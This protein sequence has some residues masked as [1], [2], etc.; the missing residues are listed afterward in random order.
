[1]GAGQGFKA[2]A[3]LVQDRDA[4][5]YELL[6]S[7]EAGD[8]RGI[9]CR[10]WA[11]GCSR[12]SFGLRS[13][14]FLPSLGR[15]GEGTARGPRGWA[16]DPAGRAA[17]VFDS[18]DDAEISE[19]LRLRL[20]RFR[21]G[22]RA[23]LGDESA[24]LMIGYLISEIF[25]RAGSPAQ[26]TVSITDFRSLLL[27]D[28][29]TLARALGRRDWGSWSGRFPR[30]RT[31][32]ART[33]WTTW[34]PLSRCG[35]GPLERPPRTLTGMS[36]IGKTS[37]A[38]GYLL[39]RADV[40]DTIFWVDAE[41]EQTL[42]SSFSRIF[43]FLRGDD[44]PEPSDPAG[45]RDAVLTD[46]SCVAGPWLLI[47]DNCADERLADGWVPQAEEWSCDSDDYSATPARRRATRG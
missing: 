38:V 30:S 39:D 3:G 27:V 15:P 20:R 18:R 37:L 17:A 36:G 2:L 31:C 16:P 4:A 28:G 40:Y 23:G 1:M 13:I 45:L 10:C 35:T 21:N 7:A 5:R 34:S 12:G 26:A 42:A 44:V 6:T 33:S 41:S 43:R 25:R 29:T 8:P 47:L 32:G 14:R 22:A 24:G 46:L 19:S 9:W 11:R